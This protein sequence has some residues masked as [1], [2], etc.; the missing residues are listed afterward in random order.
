MYEAI[1][2]FYDLIHAD[3]TADIPFLLSLAAETN[4]PIL[5]LGCGTG[6]LLLPLARAGYKITGLDSSP[7]MLER[8]RQRLAEEKGTE[9][10]SGELGGTQEGE[11][12]R[13]RV[14]LVE[15]DMTNFKLDGRF[16]L[17]IIPYNTLMHLSPPQAT[18]A[19]RQ[20]ASHL[21]KDGR[22]F[23]D[24]ANPL[25]VAQTPN[26]RMLTLE[27]CATLSETGQMLVV[28]ASTRVDPGDQTLDIIW[29][30]DTSPAGGGPVHRT[31]VPMHYH[32]FFP[33]ELEL[34]LSGAGLT[35]AGMYGD[36]KGRPFTEESERLL[37]VA[38]SR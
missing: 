34:M 26:D 31:V 36:Y 33:H 11:A 25:V 5:E 7:A 21:A 8:A 1:A 19:F 32:Y 30:Y 4:G 13:E 2:P 3:L 18:A 23:L 27:Q 14:T 9:R 22:L 29:F 24:V 12:V 6:R 10:N 37:I 28:T 38:A 16:P 20:V 35:L 17:A 15:G